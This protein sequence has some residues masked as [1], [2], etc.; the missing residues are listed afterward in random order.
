MPYQQ[1]FG[2]PLAKVLAIIN[3]PDTDIE[4]LAHAV[5][6]TMPDYA[7]TEVQEAYCGVLARLLD[8]DEPWTPATHGLYMLVSTNY[9]VLPDQALFRQMLFSPHVTPAEITHHASWVL[10]ECVD[11]EGEDDG[12]DTDGVDVYFGYVE[13]RCQEADGDLAQHLRNIIDAE[14]ERRD[15]E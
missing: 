2:I 1:V 8:S 14:N 12:P 9:E 6:A 11:T 7:V 15:E 5:N 3:N 13:A 4:T 10:H